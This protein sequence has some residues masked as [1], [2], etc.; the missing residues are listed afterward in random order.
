MPLFEAYPFGE[1][2]FHTATR[3]RLEEF[4]SRARSSLCVRQER[5]HF[6]A[7]GPLAGSF[8]VGFLPYSYLGSGL[9][10]IEN[11]KLL[12]LNAA[13]RIPFSGL[14]STRL[15]SSII[16]TKRNRRRAHILI[17]F[18]RRHR[19]PTASE[20]SFLFHSLRFG[21]SLPGTTTAF[22]VRFFTDATPQR[23]LQC[24]FVEKGVSQ[25][26]VGAVR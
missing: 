8:S 4:V 17:Y 12:H 25:P 26:S 20:K 5:N 19:L 2:N 22:S 15:E 9:Y 21:E 14:D 11:S 13:D 23:A 18:D 10:A 24:R 7:P 16:R 3:R 6:H 1:C